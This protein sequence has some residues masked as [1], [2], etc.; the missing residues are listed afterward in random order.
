MTW[1]F[2]QGPGKSAGYE[3]VRT[4]GQAGASRLGVG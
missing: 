4:G 1:E 3:E 2:K